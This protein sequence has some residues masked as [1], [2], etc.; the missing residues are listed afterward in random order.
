MENRQKVLQNL[1]DANQS[2]I[3]RLN[4]RIRSYER[5]FPD[6]SLLRRYSP[7]TR[8][9]KKCF[10]PGA[11]R[12]RRTHSSSSKTIGNQFHRQVYHASNCREGICVCERQYGTTTKPPRK[13]S[14]VDRALGQRARFMKDNGLLSLVSELIVVSEATGVGTAVDELAV[15]KST[16]AIWLISWKTGYDQKACEARSRR[17][18]N[19]MNA[20]ASSVKNVPC[21]SQ[22][23]HHLQLLAEDRILRENGIEADVCVIV[24]VL[25]SSKDTY[26]MKKRS[27][28]F[29]ATESGARACWKDFSA[30]CK[31]KLRTRVYNHDMESG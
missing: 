20:R 4:P 23:Q 3:L 13:G 17:K 25:R 24:Y 30:Y 21:T 5:I 22:N 29:W 7:L 11:L 16:G 1:I 27:G 12:I 14:K 8:N 26:V 2:G 15:Q 6:E 10:Y 18:N 19:C 31:K 9:L 28:S